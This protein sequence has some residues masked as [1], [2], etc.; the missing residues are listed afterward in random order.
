[1]IRMHV[2]LA[3]VAILAAA[4]ALAAGPSSRGFALCLGDTSYVTGMDI[5]DFVRLRKA[6]TGDFL[7]FRQDGKR[8]LVTDAGVLD[9]ARK[10]LQPSDEVRREVKDLNARLK[11]Y[12]DREEEIDREDS[13]LDDA[14]DAL[15]SGD[16]E[17]ERRRIESRRLEIE[18]ERSALRSEMRPIEEEER[19]LEKREREIE[20]VVDAELERLA[21]DALRRG[22]AQPVR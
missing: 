12:E 13:A 17:A 5:D 16:D 4:P 8:H 11:P 18:A 9:A 2:R 1:M 15:E 21:D 14:E 6:R 19:R 10:A 3:A 22:L 20:V 7:W